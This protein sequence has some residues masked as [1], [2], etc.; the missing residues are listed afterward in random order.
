MYTIGLLYLSIIAWEYS[1]KVKGRGMCQH[2]INY[3]VLNLRHVGG[4]VKLSLGL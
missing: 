1:K 2:H 3:D 4:F